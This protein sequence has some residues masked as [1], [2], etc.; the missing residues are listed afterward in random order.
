MAVTQDYFDSAPP[1]R[2]ATYA[3]LK[4]TRT[5]LQYGVA[6]AQERSGALGKLATCL[7]TVNL[8]LEAL[9]TTIRQ[10]GSTA[11]ERRPLAGQVFAGLRELDTLLAGA[12]PWLTPGEHA[13][14]AECGRTMDHEVR[15]AVGDTLPA[16]T[17]A[18]TQPPART[19]PPA[20]QGSQRSD[21]GVPAAS[22]RPL[23]N[24]GWVRTSGAPV[25]TA[26]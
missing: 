20:G 25:N 8:C 12:R 19:G 26:R 4:A 22:T 10:R 5:A 6:Q 7:G 16:R 2:R 21:Y 23:A 13:Q 9:N 18:L 17:L 14:V 15:M 3:Q 1:Q 11:T 24:G